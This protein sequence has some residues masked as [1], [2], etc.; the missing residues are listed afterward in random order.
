MK[1]EFLNILMN[2][3]NKSL[4]SEDVPVGTIIV[5]DGV[6]IASG[7][8]TR[9]KYQ[10]VLGHAEINAIINAQKKLNNWNLSG[11]LLYVT[12]APCSMCLEVIKQCRIES[13]YYLLEK[14]KSKKEFSKTKIIKLNKKKYEDKSSEILKNF[15]KKMREK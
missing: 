14:P 13:V 1:D 15:F 2:N 6:I 3:M 7:Y 9:E 8:N 5:K 11:C 12:L 10:N 4:E